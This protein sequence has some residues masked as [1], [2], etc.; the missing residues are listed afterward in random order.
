MLAR[1]RTR[2]QAHV[3]AA[4]LLTQQQHHNT[5]GAQHIT[6]RTQVTA[7]AAHLTSSSPLRPRRRPPPTP[8]H[9]R[10]AVLVVWSEPRRGGRRQNTAHHAAATLVVRIQTHEQPARA[11]AREA[12]HLWQPLHEPQQHAAALALVVRVPAPR[13][14]RRVSHT[15][16]R[17]ACTQRGIYATHTNAR[18]ASTCSRARRAHEQ[19]APRIPNVPQLL[20]VPPC[21]RGSV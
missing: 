10:L 18:A 21:A 17:P 11:R 6:R 14:A 19:V 4:A 13:A 9:V 2:N 15:R 16:G 20:R 7:C 5:R 8:P 3:K 1:V 12:P